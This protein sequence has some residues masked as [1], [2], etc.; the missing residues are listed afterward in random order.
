MRNLKSMGKC[1]FGDIISQIY[2][3][4]YIHEID[5]EEVSLTFTWNDE[6][7]YL[8][9]HYKKDT[10]NIVD[11][12]NIV[13]DYFEKFYKYR[14]IVNNIINVNKLRYVTT[15]DSWLP[16]KKQRKYAQNN[17][18]YW[19]DSVNVSK[20]RTW[21]NVGY[22]VGSI[23]KLILF[24]KRTNP[25]FKFTKISYRDNLEYI[26]KTVEKSSYFIGYDGF[27][28]QIASMLNIPGMVVTNPSEHFKHMIRTTFIQCPW[29]MQ[30]HNMDIFSY[31]NLDDLIEENK[32]Y[33][34][35]ILNRNKKYKIKCAFDRV[36]TQRT[37]ITK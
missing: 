16:I 9:K 26:F 3:I 18:V 23:N 6:E 17:I 20:T 31:G 11:V 4:Y 2:S 7:Q 30:L 8:G 33:M 25:K 13:C 37:I 5:G 34:K 24:L 32:M 27:A 35:K 36:N 10:Y 28:L 12:Q 15:F 1:G 21:K 19:D 22:D 14:P 29:S